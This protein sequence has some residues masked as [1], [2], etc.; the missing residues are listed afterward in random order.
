MSPVVVL[1]R[2]IPHRRGC[3]LTVCAIWTQEIGL[4]F[5]CVGCVLL[6]GQFRTPWISGSRRSRS[7]RRSQS[8]RFWQQIV[9]LLGST[10][11]VIEA[12]RIASRTSPTAVEL[13]LEKGAFRLLSFFRRCRPGHRRCRGCVTLL[14]FT[15]S[16]SFIT[17]IP[18]VPLLPLRVVR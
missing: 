16:F 9:L 10:F 2:T 14:S 18:F 3:S 15:L 13:G 1:A 11:S 6:C 4:R 8:M 17:F 5:G 7:S 12:A